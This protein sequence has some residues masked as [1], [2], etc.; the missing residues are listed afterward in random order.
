[1]R[2]V[3][4][5]DWRT[6]IGAIL[7]ALVTFA[8]APHSERHR[9]VTASPAKRRAWTYNDIPTGVIGYLVKM[10]CSERVICESDRTAIRYKR[11][12]HNLPE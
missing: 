9:R 6:V 7:E 11:R 2:P 5:Y 3:R 12:Q 8:Y 10:H 4:E 1:M